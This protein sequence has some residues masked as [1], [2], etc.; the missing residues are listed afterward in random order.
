MPSKSTLELRQQ[1]GQLLIMGLDGTS[2]STRLRL[3]LATLCPAGVI[4]FKRNI[5]EATQIHA[6][7]REASKAVS[8]PMFLC[9]DMEGG[10]VDRL[11]DVIAPVP[12]VADV[13]VAGSKK[14][15]RNHGRILGEEVRALG[16]NTDFAPDARPAIGG[17]EECADITDGL[18]RSESGDPV[19]ARV[20]ARNA[21]C[22]CYWLRKALPRAGR[23]QSRLASWPSRRSPSPGNGCGKR[24]CFLIASCTGSCRLSWSRMLPIRT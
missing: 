13:A 2:V 16:F 24:T 4:L 7:L 8:T 21:G 12:S 15:F 19:R 5:A 10:T 23:S 17:I 14:V 20:F 11:R 9:V 18:R 22:K 6:L 3:M 1:V